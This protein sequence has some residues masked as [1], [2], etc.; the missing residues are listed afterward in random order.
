MTAKSAQRCVRHHKWLVIRQS[1]VLDPGKQN[2][3]C[4]GPALIDHLIFK[5][6]CLFILKFKKWFQIYHLE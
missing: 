2:V 6:M 3:S 5:E 1:D 4:S